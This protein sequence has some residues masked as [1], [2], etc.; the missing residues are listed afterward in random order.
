M[1][2]HVDMV[3]MTLMSAIPH[4]KGG[5]PSAGVA[6]EERLR[7]LPDVP[8]V[9]EAGFPGFDSA[10]WN[11]MFAPAGTPPDIIAK[12][13]AESVGPCA[14]QTSDACS[15]SRPPPSSVAPRKTSRARSATRSTAAEPSQGSQPEDRLD[16]HAL[17]KRTNDHEPTQRPRR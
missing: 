3:F 11:G 13:N 14:S 9:K 4:L 8:T 10:S 17:P 1:A 7:Q 6:A 12:L 5:K 16:H 15:K 2:G